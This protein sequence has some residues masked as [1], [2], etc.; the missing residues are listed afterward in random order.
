MFIDF[1]EYGISAKWEGG[2]YID[3]IAG[4]QPFHTLNVWDASRQTATIPFTEEALRA[5][6]EEWVKEDGADYGIR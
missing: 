4:G 1:E 2:E 6:V 3:L 5:K